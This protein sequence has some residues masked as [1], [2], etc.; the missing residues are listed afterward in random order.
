[1]NRVIKFRGQKV[2]NGELVYGQL[3]YAT[4]KDLGKVF[5]FNDKGLYEIMPN[6][7]SQFTGKKDCKGKE[8]YEGDIIEFDIKEWGGKGNI[9][10]VSWNEEYAEWS[11]GGGTVFDMNFRT[12]IGNI[13]ENR[14]LFVST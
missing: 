11:W 5:I 7:E 14:N 12:V 8:I 6:T 1:M 9:H 10:V 4:G 13:F 3:R 2:S